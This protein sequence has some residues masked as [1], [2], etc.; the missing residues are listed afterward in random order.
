MSAIKPVEYKVL[1]KLVEV[2][3]QTLGGI[4]IPETSRER[5]EMAQCKASL[6]SVGGNAFEGWA[7]PKP[8]VGDRVLI[9]KYAGYPIDDNGIKYRVINDKDITAILE[10]I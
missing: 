8:K 5:E 4:I 3:K 1:V 6:I 2:E 9:G 10:E 7:E